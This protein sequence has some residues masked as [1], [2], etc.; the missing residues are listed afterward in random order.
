MPGKLLYFFNLL[1]FYSPP[2]LPLIHARVSGNYTNNIDSN[3]ADLRVLNQIHRDLGLKSTKE[4][5][6]QKQ[7]A[8]K[9]PNKLKVFVAVIRAVARMRIEARNWAAHKKTRQRLVAQWEAQDRKR[10]TC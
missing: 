9:P 1:H 10:L 7:K 2:F 3:K 4:L 6:L 8:R 5:L